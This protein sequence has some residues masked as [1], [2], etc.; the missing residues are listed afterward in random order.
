MI[1][2]HRYSLALTDDE[3][4]KFLLLKE[5]EIGIKKIFKKGLEE[6]IR[7]EVLGK[8]EQEEV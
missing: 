4:Q 8:I 1:N 3:E 2:Y 5:K 7:L 6:L